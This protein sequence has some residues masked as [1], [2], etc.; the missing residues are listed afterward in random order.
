M[1]HATVLTM[2]SSLIVFTHRIFPQTDS[3]SERDTSSV[4]KPSE[5]LKWDLNATDAK[6]SN[7]R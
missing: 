5:M 6:A 1:L 4:P 3:G 2:K 7:S